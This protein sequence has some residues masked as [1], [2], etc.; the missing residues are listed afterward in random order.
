MTAI[1][2]PLRFLS[3]IMV[4]TEQGALRVLWA[5]LHAAVLRVARVVLQ[6]ASPGAAV[7]LRGSFAAGEPVY[8]FSDLDLVVVTPDAGGA[9]RE[10]LER[11]WDRWTRAMPSLERTLAIK[12]YEE[13]ELAEASSTTVLTYGLDGP[14]ARSLFQGP[15]RHYLVRTR[16]NLYGP[17]R[18]WR[19]VGGPDRR[20]ALP[21]PE[22]H[23][24][25]AVGW[26]ELQCWWRYVAWTCLRPDD[27]GVSY[28]C[29]KFVAEAAR[30]WLWVV[31]GERANGRLDALRRARRLMPEDEA[32]LAAALETR[33][34]LGRRSGTAHA[35]AG[36]R[37]PTMD[38][39]L[40]LATVLPWL[41]DFSGRLARVVADGVE[42]AGVTE[43]HLRWSGR[44]D[45][46]GALP[47]VDWR[48]LVMDES[49]DATFRLDD[50][51]PGDPET[52]ARAAAAE[53]HGA[54]VALRAPGVLLLPSEDLESRPLTRGTLR[55]VQ[56]AATDPVSF[57]VTAGDPV[58]RFP[59]VP[60]WSA[61]DWA[62]RAVAEHG[63]RLR[64]GPA[65]D[66]PGLLAAARA[67][68]FLDSLRAGTPELPLTSA[69]VNAALG[70]DPDV[71]RTTLDA[72]VRALPAFAPGS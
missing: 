32:M 56:C 55:G 48:A 12:V 71:D 64:A 2:K 11:P 13:S 31:H 25:L 68:L 1:A 23:D 40:D 38:P 27:R 22:G 37:R 69:D 59:N 66:R 8:G 60:G 44:A 19:L 7:Y 49:P 26:L 5:G 35:R 6:A 42:P 18:D 24:R 63:A 16:P 20:P 58:A 15:D 51:S 36:L 33:R 67:G 72:A 10:R 4:R 53:R 70:L 52:V 21:V 46:D 28:F 65:P 17:A 54:P 30:I 62:R 47:L 41:V 45:A 34:R 39:G 43:V 9:A 14:V 29:F 50:S 57:A 3:A 61:R